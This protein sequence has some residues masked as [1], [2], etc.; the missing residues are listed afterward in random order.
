MSPVVLSYLILRV[1]R[2]AAVTPALMVRPQQRFRSFHNFLQHFP[3]VLAFFLSCLLVASPA[4][5]QTEYYHHT[6][7]DNGPRTSSYFDSTGKSVAP[8]A[9]ELQEDRLPLDSKTFLTP[10]NSLRISWTSRAGG[11]WAANISVAAFRN[12]EISF[13]GDSLSF[14]IFSRD[15]VPARNLPELRL[16]DA[17]RNFSR[18][19]SLADFCSDLPAGNGSRVR[20]PLARILTGSVNPFEPRHLSSITFAQSLAD[21]SPHTLFL[22]EIRIDDAAS[23]PVSSS[24]PSAPANLRLRP[25]ER[26]IDLSW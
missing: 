16:Q 10:P 1:P 14:W 25:Y 21:D 8:S 5:A 26:H 12:R 6:F 11:S 4:R 15:P 18:P 20:I 22:D 13:S 24:V 17:A 23:P 7:F 3:Y 9:L 19:L 2:G